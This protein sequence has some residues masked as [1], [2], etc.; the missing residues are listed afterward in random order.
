MRSDVTEDGGEEGDD[1]EVVGLLVNPNPILVEGAAAGR[2]MVATITNQEILIM[3]HTTSSTAETRS[4][5]KGEDST[6]IRE[7]E[8]ERFHRLTGILPVID[9][10][11]EQA[12]RLHLGRDDVWSFE[13][14]ISA[15]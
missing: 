12:T 1:G 15:D 6:R 11:T 5:R 9:Y 8:L 14:K 7:S 13:Q 3:K 4:V 10:A 2:R